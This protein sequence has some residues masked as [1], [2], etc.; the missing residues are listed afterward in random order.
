MNRITEPTDNRARP[1][2]YDT[3]FKE[4]AVSLLP[5]GELNEVPSIYANLVVQVL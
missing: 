1:A 4:Q 3:A 2:Q 5:F